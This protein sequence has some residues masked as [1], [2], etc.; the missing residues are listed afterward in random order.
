MVNQYE[1]QQQSHAFS[2]IVANVR[3]L[4]SQ[5]LAPKID[6]NGQPAGRVCLRDWIVLDPE[7][8]EQIIDAGP[9]NHVALMNKWM[10]AG[11]RARSMQT[12]ISIELRRGRITEETAKLWLKRYGYKSTEGIV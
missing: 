12:S 10:D 9:A 5:T 4:M 6:E 8:A 7:R 1:Y 2:E 11:E 3:L